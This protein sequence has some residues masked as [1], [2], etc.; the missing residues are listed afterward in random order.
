MKYCPICGELLPVASAR[1]CPEC[2]GLLED[3]DDVQPGAGRSGREQDRSEARGGSARRGAT[4]T[5]TDERFGEPEPDLY[6]DAVIK[7]EV[8]S[9]YEEPEATQTPASSRGG[10][11]KDRAVQMRVKGSGRGK[12]ALVILC[13]LLLLGALAGF[14]VLQMSAGKAPMKAA[15]A[16]AD[17][18]NTG[19]SA[20]VLANIE[21]SGS[22]L[23]SSGD[24]KK[25]MD[26]MR[27]NLD[28]KALR[29][30]LVATHSGEAG[31][32]NDTYSCFVLKQTKDTLFSQKFVVQI[33]PVQ[34]SVKTSVDDM[35]LYV[36]DKKAKAEKSESGLVLKLAPGAHT[37][38]AVYEAY[39]PEYELGKSEVLSFSA[40]EPEEITVTKNL[41][42]VEI[43]LAG[44]ETGV[45]VLIDNV[46]TKIAPVG[47]FVELSPAFAGM[48]VTVKCDQYTQDF[49]IETSGDHSLA[50]DYLTKAEQGAATPAEM[51]NR[52]LITSAAP[53]FYSFYQSYLEAINR[54]DKKLIKNVSDDYLKD[55]IVKMETYNK[56]LMF[57]FHGMTFDRRSLERKVT[58][59]ELYVT[60]RVQVDYDYAYK[61]DNSKWFAG[62]N[63]QKVTMHYDTAK[64]AWE[65]YGSEVSDKMTFSEDV[66]TINP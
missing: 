3:T 10:K 48:T 31:S 27:E 41:A 14:L 36:D 2:G 61:S 1:F 13:A 60:F 40:T 58:Q 5:Q 21:T 11:Q 64:K 56:D 47:G 65:V 53:G 26:S 55:A 42:T 30:H 39:G 49:A 54:W 15:K 51:T 12:I 44:T 43:E 6:I 25:M 18:V 35:A 23:V 46:K 57:N 28:M 20:Y 45:Q 16:F 32:T 52:Q 66:F 9:Q 8:S 38:H 34:V 24:V 22:G 7:E 62:G 37:L 50:V 59:G 19:D 4:A 33:K 63:F 29:D 17:A